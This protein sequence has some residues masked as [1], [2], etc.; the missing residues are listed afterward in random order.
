MKESDPKAEQGAD[1]RRLAYLGTLASGLAHEIRNPL[2]SMKMILQ[3]LREDW[4]EAEADR[5]LRS[6]K[7]VEI[8]LG[9]I[10]RLEE[11]LDDFLRFARGYRLD[12]QPTQINTML[13]EVLEF[14][15]PEAESRSIRIL[16]LFD[17]Q[18]STYPLD[19]KHFKQALLNIIVNSEQA[20]DNG[21]DMM[22]RSF[23]QPDHIR[24]EVTDTGKG[25]APENLDRVFD[26][27][28]S[29]KK[30]GTGLGLAFTKRIIEEHGGEILVR[31]ETGKGT[32]VSILLPLPPRPET[33]PQTN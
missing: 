20:M 4:T 31:S 24:L 5:E 21:G 14:V 1:P 12:R 11:I 13:K 30:G 8:L 19:T 17:D 22:V 32:Q 3:L 18:V 26:V 10:D 6:L 7:K 23:L 16:S 28:W 27:Y 25:I 15:R 33:P 2:G 9:E 29:N